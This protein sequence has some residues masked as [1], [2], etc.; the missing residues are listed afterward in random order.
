MLPGYACNGCHAETNAAAGE[1]EAPIFALSGTVY[2]TAHE[3]DGCVG[4]GAQGAE[5]EVVSATGK[6][7]VA[8]A[9]RVGNFQ[10]ESNDIEYPITASVRFQGRVRWMIEPQLDFDCNHCHSSAGAE[11]ASGRIRLP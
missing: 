7:F 5:I 6:R 1:T 8:I 9:N 2:P 4:S 3:P 10:F 11:G